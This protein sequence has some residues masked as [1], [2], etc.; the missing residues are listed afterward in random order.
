[1]LFDW[2]EFCVAYNIEFLERGVGIGKG[3]IGNETKD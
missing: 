1:M 3:K 2:L